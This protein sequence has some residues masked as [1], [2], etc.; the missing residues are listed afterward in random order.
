VVPALLD[1]QGKLVGLVSALF[2][3]G[4][5]QLAL[6]EQPFGE[7]RQGSET[8]FVRRMLFVSSLSPIVEFG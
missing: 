2:I 5:P 8:R 3:R 6:F 7:N 4:E 1:L